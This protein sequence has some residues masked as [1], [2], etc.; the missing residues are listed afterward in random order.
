MPSAPL[1]ANAEEEEKG[2]GVDAALEC[3][4]T[5]CLRT[6]DERSDPPD[7]LFGEGDRAANERL[8]CEY[9]ERSV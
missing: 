1:L 8:A 3:S 9:N 5:L 7:Q 4:A 6:L 2:E